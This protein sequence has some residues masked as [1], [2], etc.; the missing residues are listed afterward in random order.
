MLANVEAVAG[1][2]EVAADHAAEAAG[3]FDRLG[4]VLA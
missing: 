3:Y 2:D 4:V 1:N